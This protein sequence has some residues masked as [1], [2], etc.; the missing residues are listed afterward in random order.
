LPTHPTA[1]GNDDGRQLVRGILPAIIADSVII[2]GSGGELDRRV[3]DPPVPGHLI[4]G[5]PGI[6]ALPD[7]AQARR[8]DEDE[9]CVA[10][11]GTYLRRTL[12]IDIEDHILAARE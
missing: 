6:D 11:I 3:L 4:L 8:H 12:H 1:L 10:S 2:T 9:D 7:L 5:P